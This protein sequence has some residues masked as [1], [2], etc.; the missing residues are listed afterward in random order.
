MLYKLS[1][2]DTDLTFLGFFNLKALEKVAHD[3]LVAKP[4]D[5]QEVVNMGCGG[6]RD[7]AVLTAR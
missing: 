6:N 4:C 2:A 7:L 5:A 3:P 1:A